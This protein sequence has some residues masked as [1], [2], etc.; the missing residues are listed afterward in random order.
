MNHFRSWQRV[1]WRAGYSCGFSTRADGLWSWSMIVVPK[2]VTILM[3]PGCSLTACQHCLLTRTQYLLNNTDVTTLSTTALMKQSR[4]N[5]QVQTGRV[6]QVTLGFLTSVTLPNVQHITF[7]CVSWGDVLSL[8]LLCFW[9]EWLHLVTWWHP[10]PDC[11]PRW[12]CSGWVCQRPEALV[13][14]N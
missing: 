4:K 9:G 8:L 5:T 7:R 12:V 13:I 6:D 14:W 1:T 10:G 2:W 3:W 11:L